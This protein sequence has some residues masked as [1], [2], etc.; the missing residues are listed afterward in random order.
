MSS[1]RTADLS[2]ARLESLILMKY[3]A[4]MLRQR[5]TTAVVAFSAPV[6][7]LSQPRPYPASSIHP[8]VEMHPGSLFAP[9]EGQK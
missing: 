6:A 9:A 5:G 7:A 1:L 3:H 4:C 2:R 8:L